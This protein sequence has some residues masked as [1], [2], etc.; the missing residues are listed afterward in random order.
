[1]RKTIDSLAKPNKYPII[2]FVFT[3]TLS[4]AANGLSSLAP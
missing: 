1:M 4:I 2:F 3:L